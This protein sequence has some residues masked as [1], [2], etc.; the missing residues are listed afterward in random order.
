MQS[1]F[2]PD[3]SVAHS[4]R[5]IGKQALALRYFPRSTPAT[6]LRRLERWMNQAHGLQ[7]ALLATGYRRRN[8]TLTPRQLSIVYDYLGE[9]G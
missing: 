4:P 9:P 8:R 1:F 7:D 2:L 6:A 3:H 5:P